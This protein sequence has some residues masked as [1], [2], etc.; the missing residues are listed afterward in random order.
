M[1]GTRIEYIIDN[2]SELF[3]KD[4]FWE[5]CASNISGVYFLYDENKK[6]IYIGKSVKC[7]RQRLNYHCSQDYSI[8]LSEYSLQQMKDKRNEVKYLSFIRVS[9]EFTDMVEIFFINKY[10][11]KYN[12][13][14]LYLN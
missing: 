10:K 7:I 2:F 12:K 14:F 6:I 1:I 11:P 3:L 4:E 8:Y 9:K 13:E 5:K